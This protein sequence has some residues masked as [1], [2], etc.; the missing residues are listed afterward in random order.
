M[1]NLTEL[2]KAWKEAKYSSKYHDKFCWEDY[3]GNLCEMHQRL[4]N[5]EAEAFIAYYEQAN[6]LFRKNNFQT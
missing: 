5:E 3:E 6:Y 2:Y 1:S 4:E